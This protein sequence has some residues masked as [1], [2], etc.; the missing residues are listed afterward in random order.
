MEFVKSNMLEE[1][2]KVAEWNEKDSGYVNRLLS[3]GSGSNGGWKL[4]MPFEVK[5]TPIKVNGT[6]GREVTYKTNIFP[7]FCPFCGEKNTEA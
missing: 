2:K 4:V 6:K 5:Y 3:L 1:G 7:T